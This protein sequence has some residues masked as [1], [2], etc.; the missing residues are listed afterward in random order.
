MSCRVQL[1]RILD[2]GVKDMSFPATATSRRSI[3]SDTNAGDHLH[4]VLTW[5][6]CW[7]TVM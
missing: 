1:A 7:G 4:W 6:A 3:N 5:P 2:C